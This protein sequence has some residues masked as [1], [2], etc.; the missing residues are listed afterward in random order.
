MTTVDL[1]GSITHDGPEHPARYSTELRP[2]LRSWVAGLSPILDPMA[3]VGT[4]GI[5]SLIHGELEMPWARQCPSPV[6]QGDACAL[7][8]AAE[9]FGAVICSPAYGNRMADNYGGDK[10]GSRRHTY[11]ISLGRPLR[12]ESGARMQWGTEYRSLHK[13]AWREVWRV[14]KPGGVFMLNVKDHWRKGAFQGVP[15]WHLNICLEIGFLNA[16]V[17]EVACPGQRHGQ[18]GDK[19][20]ENEIVARMVKP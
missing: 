10:R 8:F 9:T 11:R 5:P 4:L 13:A 17:K 14:L 16:T 3:G 20:A 6:Y 19:R 15:D 7:P 1:F 12:R 2:L 18:N